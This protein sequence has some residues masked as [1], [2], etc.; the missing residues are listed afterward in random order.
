[1]S[2][3]KNCPFC[4]SEAVLNSTKEFSNREYASVSCSECLV[5]TSVYSTEKGA[6]KAWNKRTDEQNLFKA[7]QEI[8]DSRFIWEVIP[9]ATRAIQESSKY[10]LEDTQ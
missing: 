8:R 4:G 3:L 7:M 9:I 10:R 2:E 6:I 5:K 1:M